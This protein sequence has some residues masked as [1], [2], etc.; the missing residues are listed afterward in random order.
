M[1][2]NR[3][4]IFLMSSMLYSYATS[5]RIRR[6]V[7]TSAGRSSVPRYYTRYLAD[8]LG[9]LMISLMLVEPPLTSV[10]RGP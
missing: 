9:G 4:E 10:I 3:S 8:R 6:F 2:G 5:S 1:T 7:S